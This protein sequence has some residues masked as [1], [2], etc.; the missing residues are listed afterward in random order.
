MASKHKTKASPLM[1]VL[2][3]FYWIIF[4]VALIIVLVYAAFR[5]F[6]TDPDVDNDHI[7][8]T[9]PVSTADPDG[10][11]DPVN[12][13]SQPPESPSPL[14]LH[15]VEGVYTCLLAG[16]DDGNGCADTLM[17]GV[18]NTNNKTASLLSIPRDTLVMVNGAA[19]KINATYAAGGMEL[20]CQA[21]EELLAV[22]VD[23]YVAVDLQAFA[24]IVDEV[25]GVWFTVPQDMKYDD[26]Y[27]DL[28]IDIKAGYQLLDGKTALQLMRFRSGYQDQ[29]IGRSRTQRAF[30]TTLVKQSITL[31]N[32]SKVTS[33]IEILNRYVDSDMPLKDMIFFATQAV[34][35]DL[36]EALVSTSLP[37]DWIYPYI[38][39]REE[40]VADLVN[41]LGLYQEE[42][43]VSALGIYH[44]EQ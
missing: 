35:M 44:K 7:I 31:S 15:R 19:K 30:L 26:P 41:S 42:V 39:L 6:V 13:D 34:G 4:A 14:V 2:K 9:P 43:P 29:D 27:Q 24:K 23:F 17:L 22:P 8:N 11:E 16:T 36:N 40:E 38:E 37:G 25:G 12:T 5:I 21:V 33:L 28:H 10:T 1:R 20:V 18:F 32:A 3:A